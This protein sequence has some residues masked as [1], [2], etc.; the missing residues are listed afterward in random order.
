M[1][2]MTLLIDPEIRDLVF[3]EGGNFKKIY[4]EDTVVQ[5]VRHALVTWKAEF[6]ADE[7]HG[8]DYE[9]IVGKNQNEVDMSE[10][11]EV[12]R[13]AIFQ[14]PYVQRVDSLEVTYDNRSVTAVFQ[15]TM[16]NGEKVRLEVTA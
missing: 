6:F 14:E 2:N 3:D 12:L 9:R 7:T 13:E 5:N 16:I 8:T 1:D 11:K 4:D 15:G 10:V